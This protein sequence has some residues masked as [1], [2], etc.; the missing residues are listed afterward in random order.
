MLPGSCFIANTTVQEYCLQR[1]RHWFIEGCPSSHGW[2]AVLGLVLYIAFFSPGMGPVP[3]AVNSEIYPSKYRGMCGGIAATVNWICNL[4]VAQSFLS[5]INALGTAKTFIVFAA[6]TLAAF[7]FVLAFVPETKG[8]SFEEVEKLWQEK[9][10]GWS[11]FKKGSQKKSL[12]DKDQKPQT[13][14]RDI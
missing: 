10:K 14:R 12:L 8:L 7:L 9:A 2:L 11:K 4:I 6:I 3:W 13:S 5:L 1:S